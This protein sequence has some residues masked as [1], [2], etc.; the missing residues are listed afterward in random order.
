MTS[1]LMLALAA[2]AFI[3]FASSSTDIAGRQTWV[4]GTQNNTQEF[5][6]S[7]VV[8]DGC[9]AYEGWTSMC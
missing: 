8:T 6:L 2:P 3:G 5:Y 1:L 4:P 9:K 7:M